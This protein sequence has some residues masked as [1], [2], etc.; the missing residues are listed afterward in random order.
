LSFSSF[1]NYPVSI[2]RT[3]AREKAEFKETYLTLQIEAAL[4]DFSAT[5]SIDAGVNY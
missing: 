4:Y 3:T 2:Q 5:D 1:N